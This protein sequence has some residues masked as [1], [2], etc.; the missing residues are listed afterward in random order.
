MWVRLL[1]AVAILALPAVQSPASSV[2]APPR[3]G[4]R[5]SRARSLE[6]LKMSDSAHLARIPCMPGHREVTIFEHR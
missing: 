2:R 3:P 6:K 4:V 1:V 5:I